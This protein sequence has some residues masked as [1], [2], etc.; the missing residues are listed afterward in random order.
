MKKIFITGATGYL[1]SKIALHA[2]NNNYY[3]KALVRDPA[4][5][6]LPVHPNIEPVKGDLDDIHSILSGM[7]NSDVVIHCAALAKLYSK[8]PNEIY[9][10][11]VDGTRN[12]LEAARM[13]LVKKF[14]F[15]SSCAVIGNSLNI[16]LTENDPRLNPLENDYEISKFWAEELV[17]EYFQDGLPAVILAPPILFGAGNKSNGNTLSKIISQA[18]KRGFAFYPSGDIYGNFAFVEDVVDGH[19]KAIKYARP[20]EKYILGG[21]NLSYKHFFSAISTC[22][23]KKIKLIPVSKSVLNI[24]SRINVTL[25][26]MFNIPSNMTPV[27]VKRIY[28]NRLLNSQKA[29]QELGYSITPFEKAFTQTLQQL[30]G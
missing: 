13:L 8:D 16:P 4:S 14:I 20:G 15:T 21:E 1:G 18:M 24:T 27:A 25:S 6:N 23:G 12:M 10:T 29:I 9:R 2:A 19:I 11:N 7:E 3:V 26:A 17:K 30:N 28:S 5:K 22:S